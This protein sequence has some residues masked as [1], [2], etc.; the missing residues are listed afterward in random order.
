MESLAEVM[1]RY[2]N[3]MFAFYHWQESRDVKSAELALNDLLA[4]R[5]AWRVHREEIP[6][7]P[8]VASVYRSMNR[9]DNPFDKTPED[10]AMAGLCEAAIKTL[11]EMRSTSSTSI[12]S[13]PTAR[14]SR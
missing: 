14:W 8:A 1:R 3:G 10:G 2:V 4:W 9:A 11:E 5:E 7:L 13:C 12:R 6:K